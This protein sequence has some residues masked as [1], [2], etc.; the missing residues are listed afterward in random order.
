MACLAKRT[1]EAGAGEQAG[2]LIKIYSCPFGGVRRP[3]T[4]RN[5]REGKHE[6]LTAT[7]QFGDQR[8]LRASEGWLE[9]LRLFVEAS[10]Q[11]GNAVTQRPMGQR[12]TDTVRRT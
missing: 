9:P 12:V 5:P 10:A 8:K 11:N 3:S 4:N 6:N 2:G 1:L 7:P